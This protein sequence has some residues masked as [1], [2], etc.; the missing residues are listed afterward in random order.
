MA[1]KSMRLMT[2]H[3]CWQ[4]AGA[5]YSLSRYQ[6]GTSGTSL[7][8]QVPAW[9]PIYKISYDKLTIHLTITTK[10]GS[11]YYARLIHKTSYKGRKTF[12]RYDSF[13]NRK[14]V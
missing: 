1:T 5:A 2:P 12:I 6:S 3:A 8:L 7:V 9:G 13:E 11:T 10:L 14:V 4:R